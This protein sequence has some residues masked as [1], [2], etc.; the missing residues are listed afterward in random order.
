MDNAGSGP[1]RNYGVGCYSFS[2]KKENK[3]DEEVTAVDVPRNTPK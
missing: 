2:S 3:R 1:C